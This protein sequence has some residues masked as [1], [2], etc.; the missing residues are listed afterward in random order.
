MGI[1]LA[2]AIAE[3]A[4][5][6]PVSGTVGASPYNCVLGGVSLFS[7]V[8]PTDST[9]RAIHYIASQNVTGGCGGGA[10]CVSQNVTRAEMGLF[11]ARGLVAPGGGAAVPLTYG[12]DPVTN[13]S[14]SC[15]AGSPNLFF[16]DITTADSY[17]KHVHY[18][19]A[20]GIVSGCSATQY[21][22]AGDVTRGE[23]ARF[24]STAFAPNLYGP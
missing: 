13:R 7:D 15:D 14:Y 11:V 5:N 18:L 23:M 8:A 19:W 2:R 22:V 4:A 3:G 24:L 20:K 10:F 6:I 16:T 17:C 12:P 21:C 9:C 1:F